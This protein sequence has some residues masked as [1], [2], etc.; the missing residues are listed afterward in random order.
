MLQENEFIAML[1]AIG[2]LIFLAVNRKNRIIQS[3]DRW[4]IIAFLL[5][6]LSLI[7]TVIEGSENSSMH[8]VFNLLEHLCGLAHYCAL[9]FWL[10]CV[11]VP[12]GKNP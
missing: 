2:I 9:T 5:L 3:S 8:K 1:I 11:F 4:L 12:K 10:W 7:F 6:T